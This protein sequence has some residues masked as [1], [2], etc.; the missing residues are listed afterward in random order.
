MKKKFEQDQKFFVVVS[1]FLE[2]T[3][4][5][6]SVAIPL[7]YVDN[8]GAITDKD[9]PK[10]QKGRY[11]EFIYA[12]DEKGRDKAR[13]YSFKEGLRRLM[14][15][16]TD[17]DIYG[18]SQYDFLKNSPFCEGSP[19]GTYD[20]KDGVQTGVMFREA[21]SAKDAKVML[22]ADRVR[23]KAEV[24]ADGL[25]EETLAEV[26]SLLGYYGDVDDLMRHYVV[27]RAG[28]DPAG[29]NKILNS[30][31]RVYR[32]IVRMALKENIFKKKG[33]VISWEETLIG[34]DED[35]AVQTLIR[36]KDILKGLESALGI[37]VEKKPGRPVG[38][39]KN[40]AS[41]QTSL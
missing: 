18:K 13:R 11:V 1:P 36:E 35:A 15:R 3:F 25:D 16:T 34:H 7:G 37:K 17:T 33:G 41:D 38:S 27:T 32:A 14:T 5:G 24:A 31:D 6:G 39:T 19:N 10:G 26:A 21:D 20:E 22:D 40:N 9:N 30:G 12:K 23:M 2:N 28:K 29:F 8:A 4:E